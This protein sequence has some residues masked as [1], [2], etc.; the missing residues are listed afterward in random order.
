MNGATKDNYSY[1]M[2]LQCVD[3]SMTARYG[4][5]VEDIDYNYRRAYLDGMGV[6][7]CADE[8]ANKFYAEAK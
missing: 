8:V 1:R 4:L 5:V 2:W 6:V 7:D 3:T